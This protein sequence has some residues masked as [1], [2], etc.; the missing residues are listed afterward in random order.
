[1]DVRVIIIAYTPIHSRKPPH[2]NSDLS[3]LGRETCHV[4]QEMK[5]LHTQEDAGDDTV[6][7]E[8]M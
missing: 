2:S 4:V 8:N 6:R 5:K 1:M 3:T 7:C